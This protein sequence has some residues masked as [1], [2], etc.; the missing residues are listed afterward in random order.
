MD[1]Q[2]FNY[3]LKVAQTGNITKAAEELY[4]TQPALS[5]FIARV[6]SEEGITIFDRSTS[7]MSLTQ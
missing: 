1:L 4:M 3:I 7:P 5:R 2:K 6:E